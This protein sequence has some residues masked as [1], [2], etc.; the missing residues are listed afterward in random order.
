MI[1]LK[2]DINKRQISL[3][4]LIF[5]WWYSHSELKNKQTENY[6]PSGFPSLASM[7]GGTVIHPHEI[8]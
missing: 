8:L 6:V 7:T 4:C 2:M 3:G 5:G 1:F